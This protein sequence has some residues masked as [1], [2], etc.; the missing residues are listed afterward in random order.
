MTSIPLA[1]HAV[2]D[3]RVALSFCLEVDN[4]NWSIFVFWGVSILVMGCAICI[5]YC[6][7]VDGAIFMGIFACF[8]ALLGI[9]LRD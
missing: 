7:D 2:C 6:A 9:L 8:S 5:Q 3:T 1:G 4:M